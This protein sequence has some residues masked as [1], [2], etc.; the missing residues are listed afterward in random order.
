[1]KNTLKDIQVKAMELKLTTMMKVAKLLAKGNKE[2][3]G[4]IEEIK[5]IYFKEVKR[6]DDVRQFQLEKGN[7]QAVMIGS[8]I[9]ENILNLPASKEKTAA[10]NLEILYKGIKDVQTYNK[11]FGQL[12]K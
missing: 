6:F 11:K 10:E 1:M 3:I 5:E 4:K 12:V 9:E 7:L 2:M 8:A